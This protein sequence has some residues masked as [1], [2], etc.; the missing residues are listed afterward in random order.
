MITIIPALLRNENDN[1]LLQE[2]LR[3]A[4]VFSPHE[5]ILI[6]QGNKP[7]DIKIPGLTNYRFVH[8]NKPLSKWGAIRHGIEQVKD[9][10]EKVVLLDGDNPFEKDSLTK[11]YAKWSS[12]NAQCLLG[13]RNKIVLK[14]KD[15]LSDAT[16]VILE[17]ITNTLFLL[18]HHHKKSVILPPAPD[19]QNCLYMIESDLLKKLDFDKIG[20]YGGEMFLFNYLLSNGVSVQNVPITPLM[21]ESSNYS[22]KEIIMNL[23]ALPFFKGVG[24]AEIDCAIKS[25]P[26][27]YRDYMDEYIYSR[28]DVESKFIKSAWLG[29]IGRLA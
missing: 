25:A 17:I 11:A 9:Q 27:V 18:R 24:S 21:R 22:A 23:A 16:R 20:S 15:Q 3:C 29:E 2:T 28:Y 5:F 26:Y 10:N 13:K 12:S 7:E 19:I 4:S 14:A 8:F 6:T 1:H